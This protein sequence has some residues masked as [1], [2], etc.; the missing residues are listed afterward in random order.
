MVNQFEGKVF[1]SPLSLLLCVSFGFI[2]QRQKAQSTYLQQQ[3]VLW[4][5]TQW[6][7]NIMPLWNMHVRLEQFIKA[8]SAFSLS[9]SHEKH[10]L[11]T[12]A[13][14]TQHELIQHIV[15]GGT[16]GWKNGTAGESQTETKDDVNWKSECYTPF[17][18]FM[19]LH[20]NHSGI[21]NNGRVL[22]FTKEFCF[23]CQDGSWRTLK[24]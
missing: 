20:S 19:P 9:F 1:C 3:Y 10:L 17:K 2:N 23:C 13:C 4:N 6:F 14:K 5:Y 11:P 8:G 15:S 21:L 16:W 24:S 22:R 12:W 7:R 18:C